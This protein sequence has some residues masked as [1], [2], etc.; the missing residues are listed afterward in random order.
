MRLVECDRARA[1]CR[2]QEFGVRK[3]AGNPSTQK[4]ERHPPLA[5]AS[6]AQTAR[7]PAHQPGSLPE[8][9][10]SMLRWFAPS[11]NNKTSRPLHARKERIPNDV[12]RVNSADTSPP[13]TF[14]PE[15]K[16]PLVG[17]RVLDLSRLVAGNMLSLQLADFGAEVI[18]IEPLEGDPLRHWRDGGEELFW[19]IYSRNKMSVALD[20]RNA[21][22]KD[23]LLRLVETAD[24]LVESFRPGTL[25]KMGLAP[26]VLLERNPRLIVVRVS[27]FGQT[28][29][30]CRASGF[31]HAGGGDERACR[32]HRFSGPRAAAAAAGSGRHDRRPLGRHGDGDGAACARPRAC[33]GTSDRSLAARAV[34]LHVS[35]RKPRFTGAPAKSSSARATASAFPRLAT[36]IAA[37]TENMWRCRAPPRPWRNASSRSSAGPR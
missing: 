15:A 7:R 14:S 1:A 23:A 26:D 20:L 30:L 25:E 33:E 31:R 9:L 21:K 11:L 37:P 36:S 22:A 3:P 18:K 12:A 6:Q 16:G 17:T 13:I 27:G 29:T 28:G 32:A 19:K 5:P 10:S 24:V 35:D 4:R 2:R 34:V 8:P